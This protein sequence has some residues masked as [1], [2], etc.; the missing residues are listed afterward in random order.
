MLSACEVDAPAP[1]GGH[2]ERILDYAFLVAGHAYGSPNDQDAGMHPPFVA[3]LNWIAAQSFEY[4]FLTGDVVYQSTPEQWSAFRSEIVECETTYHIAPGNHDLSI[5]ALYESE[6]GAR[7]YSFENGSDLFLILD[8]VSDNWNIRN[9]QLAKMLEQI[10]VPQTYEHIF[11]FVHHPLWWSP[12]NQFADIVPNSFAAYEGSTN[13]WS[14]L[15]PFLKIS[16]SQVY[17]FAGDFGATEAS[18]KLAYHQNENLHYIMSGMGSGVLD[19]CLLVEKYLNGAIEIKI[20]ALSP[21]EPSAFGTLSDYEI[22]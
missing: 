11:C 20:H 18:T 4:I 7:C 12:N 15:E 22:F 16:E 2:T 17:L 21:E 14:E 10:E 3:E 19:H 5:P 1:N 9:E 8:S 6:I 13:Y